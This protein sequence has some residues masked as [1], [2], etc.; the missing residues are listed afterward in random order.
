VIKNKEFVTLKLARSA[1]YAVQGT[2]PKFGLHAGI[3]K[4]SSL[5][6]E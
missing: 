3:V 6:E 4:C 2:W 5:N 1:I